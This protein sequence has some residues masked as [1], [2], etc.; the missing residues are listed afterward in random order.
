MLNAT[1]LGLVTEAAI[2]QALRRGLRQHFVA[3]RF[4]SGVWKGTRMPCR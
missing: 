2:T 3:G 1:K 4:D